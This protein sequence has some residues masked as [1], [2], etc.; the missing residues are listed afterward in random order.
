MCSYLKAPVNDYQIVCVKTVM[1]IL[2]RLGIRYKSEADDDGYR[3][4]S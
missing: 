4:V 1:Q 2:D 3:I